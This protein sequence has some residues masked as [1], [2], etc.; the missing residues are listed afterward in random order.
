MRKTLSLLLVLML[1]ACCTTAMAWGESNADLYENAIGLLKENKYAEAGQA[2]AALGSYSD[3]PR[4]TMYCSAIVAGEAGFYST[5]VENLQSLDGFL[6]SKLLALYYA[7]ISWEVAENYEKAADVMSG[8][9]LYKDVSTRV[10]G[11]PAKINA[12]DYR[13]ADANE[14]AGNLE[15]ALS[16]FKALGTY[17]DSEARAAAVQAKIDERDAAAAEQAR[18]DAYAAAD[19][20]EQEEHLEEALA[21]FS[22]LGT[23]QDSQDRAAVVQKKIDERDAAEAEQTKADAYAAAD[24]AEQD[25]DYATAY[26]GFAALGDYSDSAARAAAVKDKGN[27]AQALQYCMEGKFSQ[28]YTLFTELGSYEDSQEKAYALG[29]TTFASVSDRGN[30][31]AAFKFHNLWGLININ[32]NATVSPYWDE[33]GPFNQFGLAKVSKDGYSGYINTAGEVVVPCDW[34]DTSDFNED[35]LCTVVRCTETSSG[36]STY[37]Y[38]YF[39]LYDSTGKEITPAQ[40]RTLGNSTNSSWRE[41]YNGAKTHAPAFSDGKAMVQNADGL[42]GFID[43]SGHLVGEVRWSSIR[44]FSENLA[45]VVENE[46]YGFIDQNGQVVIEPQ[47]ADALPFSE[48]LAGVKKGGLWQFINHDN[49]VVIQPKYGQVSSFSDGKADV[50]LNGTGWQIIDSAGGLLYFVNENTV[51]AYQAAKD[52]FDA[53]QYSEAFAEFLPLA[54][55]KDSNELANEAGYLHAKGLMENE[56][57]AEAVLMFNALHGYKDS[58]ELAAEAQAKIHDYFVVEEVSGAAYGF[59]LNNEGWYESRNHG[60]GNSYAICKIRFQTTTG[61]FTLDCINYAESGYDFGLISQIDGSLSN[62]S[63]ADSG[64]YKSFSNSNSSSA[65]TVTFD[66]PD[67]NE[68]VIYIKYIKDGSGNNGYDSFRFQVK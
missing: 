68:H 48:S 14:Q 56:A 26:S 65:V 9:T 30:G 47:Y 23:Y 24:Q 45:V 57:Y 42:Y 10:A 15:S 61:H 55:Y 38:Y 32:T 16:G 20:A 18:A 2:F 39:G 49:E 44:N 7:G 13:K 40:W 25:G 8:I 1:A 22:A 3:S 43:A 28:A 35:G 5:A 19:Q 17:Q 46:L 6:D 4:Y 62:N 51:M 66:V 11:Y 34:Y 50:F 64:V 29:V 41:T 37:P 27:Y 63:S 59:A 67:Q 36:W 53:G 58:A 52:K 21:G 60:I 54:G 31:I 33:I 12:R